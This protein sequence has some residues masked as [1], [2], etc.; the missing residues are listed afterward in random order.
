[1]QTVAG[2][3]GTPQFRKCLIPLSGDGTLLLR[4]CRNEIPHEISFH[5]TQHRRPVWIALP[6]TSGHYRRSRAFEEL[7]TCRR[8]C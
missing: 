1:M 8:C 4:T 3:L 5:E 2:F 6:S 7:R